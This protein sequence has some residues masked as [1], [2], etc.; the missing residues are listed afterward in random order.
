MSGWSYSIDGFRYVRKDRQPAG[1]G[2]VWAEVYGVRNAAIYRPDGSLYL[3]N[4][5][6]LS[7]RAWHVASV[8]MALANKRRTR[9]YRA[10]VA[11]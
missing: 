9:R 6:S 4:A 7:K 11:A 1:F 5:G 2:E 10:E 8:R 3:A